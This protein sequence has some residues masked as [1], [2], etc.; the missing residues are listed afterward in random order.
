MARDIPFSFY[1]LA[2]ELLSKKNLG[3]YALADQM[4]ITKAMA[5]RILDD[6]KEW[7]MAKTYGKSSG[8]KG[9]RL[10]EKGQRMSNFL[11]RKCKVYFTD[12]YVIPNELQLN[13]NSYCV[14]ALREKD[15]DVKGITG[16]FERD[17]AVRHGADGAVVVVKKGRKWV[18]PNDGAET[19]IKPT[20]IPEDKVLI[21]S[22]A[23]SQGLA[24]V[25]AVESAFTHVDIAMLKQMIIFQEL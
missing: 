13:S 17:V 16:V 8:R 11:N 2:F 12:T 21:V 7:D 24:N 9:T 6:L 4:S 22:F 5:R 19:E 20:N 14:V 23:S 25:S 10:T 18:F 3:R 1:F 15:L